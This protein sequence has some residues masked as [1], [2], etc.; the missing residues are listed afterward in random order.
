[1]E[2][3]MQVSVSSILSVLFF[4]P[5]DVANKAAFVSHF[6]EATKVFDADPMILPIGNAPPQVP[7]IVMKSRD[8]RYVCEV[9][10]DRLSFAYHDAKKQK[11][12]LESLYPEYRDVLHHVI[13]AAMAGLSCPIV[14]LGFVTRHLIELGDGA[15]EWLRQ[16]YL[17]LER[18]PA[19]HETHLHLLHRLPME[20][21]SVNRW[22][23]IWTL[24]DQQNAERDPAL[25]VEIDI[26]TIPE[27][28]R[29]FDRSEIVAFFLDA[30]DRAEKDLKAYTLDFIERDTD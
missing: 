9:A 29:R 7:R 3:P 22:I 27:A 8:G 18:V 28:N 13:V 24:R 25:A 11:R 23:K 5:R 26:N 16:T 2:T 15:N 10:L 30:F 21:A 19:A 6:T 4:A 12:T 17:R 1:M 14:R 20:S